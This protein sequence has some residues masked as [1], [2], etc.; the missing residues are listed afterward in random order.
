LLFALAFWAFTSGF[1]CGKLLEEKRI[2]EG[3]MLKRK[4][5]NCCKENANEGLI[6]SL[7]SEL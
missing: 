4:G 1:C 2:I 6:E 3:K 7:Q 5:K